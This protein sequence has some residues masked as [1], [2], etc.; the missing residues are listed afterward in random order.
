MAGDKP[1]N[2]LTRGTTYSFNEAIDYLKQR[3]R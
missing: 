1:R 2:L 3:D